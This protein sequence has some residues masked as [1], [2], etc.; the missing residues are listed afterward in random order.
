MKYVFV[1]MYIYIKEGEI[2]IIFSVCVCVCV[3]IYIYISS[4]RMMMDHANISFA[5]NIPSYLVRS[6]CDTLKIKNEAEI[7]K[8]TNNDMVKQYNKIYSPTQNKH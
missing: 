4:E 8:V 1:C 2:L 5:Q 7:L 3:C 6:T